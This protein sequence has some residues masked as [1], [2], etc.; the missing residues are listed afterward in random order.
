MGNWFGRRRR[1]KR[2]EAEFDSLTSGILRTDDR[3]IIV[4]PWTFEAW[5][6][7]DDALQ[8]RRASFDDEATTLYAKSQTR[9]AESLKSASPEVRSALSQKT[10]HLEDQLQ[11]RILWECFVRKTPREEFAALADPLHP[12]TID[13]DDLREIQAYKVDLFALDMICVLLKRDARDVE[14]NEH[15]LGWE[16]FTSSM[17]RRFP[18]IR[19]DW[20]HKVAYPTFEPN[21][22]ILWRSG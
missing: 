9:L 8:G 20:F 13:W 10:D 18:G 11:R 6:R 17:V 2:F 4:V 19:P 7:I 1:R 5:L 22:L 21:P 12:A 16:D 15:M 14:I 3:G